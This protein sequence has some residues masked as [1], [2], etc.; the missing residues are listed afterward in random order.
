MFKW[1][2][3]FPLIGDQSNEII[4]SNLYLITAHETIKAQKVRIIFQSSCNVPILVK[5]KFLS[6]FV[7]IKNVVNQNNEAS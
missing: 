1:S 7:C 2:D 3:N 6:I 4:L 5:C